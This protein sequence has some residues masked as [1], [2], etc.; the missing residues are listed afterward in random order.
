[1]PREMIMNIVQMP[2]TGKIPTNNK[3]FIRN[4]LDFM[5]C[6]LHIVNTFKTLH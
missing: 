4:M 5:Q 1:M 3:Y 6:T 2:N